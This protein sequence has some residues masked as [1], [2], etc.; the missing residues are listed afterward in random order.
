MISLTVFYAKKQKRG[1]WMNIKTEIKQF[2]NWLSWK[3]AAFG[4]SFLVSTK[5]FTFKS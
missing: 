3:I 4:D 1:D 2:E 5:M